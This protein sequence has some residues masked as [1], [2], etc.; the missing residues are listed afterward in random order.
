MRR[1]RLQRCHRQMLTNPAHRRFVEVIGLVAIVFAII[2]VRLT[3][4]ETHCYVDVNMRVV[5]CRMT[6]HHEEDFHVLLFARELCKLAHHSIRRLLMKVSQIHCWHDVRSEQYR[7]H[8]PDCQRRF[9]PAPLCHIFDDNIQT[10]WQY[11]EKESE[12]LMWQQWQ[13]DSSKE[14]CLQTN[15]SFLWALPVLDGV[16]NRQEERHNEDS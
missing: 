4:E 7:R 2:K 5:R 6:R 8:E 13:H 16:A 3:R 10:E 14:N 9:G 1:Q 12:L 15:L 11:D